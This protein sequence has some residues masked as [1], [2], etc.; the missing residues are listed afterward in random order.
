MIKI[1]AF[2]YLK[3]TWW[4]KVLTLYTVKYSLVDSKNILSNLIFGFL[5]DI[6]NIHNTFII[7]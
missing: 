7:S 3:G 1:T 6:Y 5:I 2:T 4:T